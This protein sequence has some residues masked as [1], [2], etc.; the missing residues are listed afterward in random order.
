MPIPFFYGVGITLPVILDLFL[1]MGPLVNRGLV[2]G[3][4]LFDEW[5]CADLYSICEF[6]RLFTERRVRGEDRAQV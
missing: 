4:G 2:H 5:R 3:L 6:V 1:L